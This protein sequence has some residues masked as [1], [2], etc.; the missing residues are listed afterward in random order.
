MQLFHYQAFIILSLN[1]ITSFSYSV[2]VTQQLLPYSSSLVMHFGLVE[3]R[4]ETGYY[5]GLLACS[6]MV[7]RTLLAPIWGHLADVHGRK[8]L[9]EFSVLSIFVIS[10]LFS[11]VPN[12]L[13]ALALRLMLG[14]LNSLS[15]VAKSAASECVPKEFVSYAMMMYTTG[16]FIGEVFGTGLGGILVGLVFED[17]PYA[18]PNL[19][20]AFLALSILLV[21]RFQFVETLPP[22]QRSSEPFSIRVL[23][24]IMSTKTVL[25]L[26]TIYGLSCFITLAMQEL[27]PLICW[28]EESVGG[29]NMSPQK[30][31]GVLTISCSIALIVQQF[32]YGRIVK[33][34]G[35]YTVTMKAQR[36]MLPII[37]LL[38]FTKHTGDYYWV[39]LVF[40]LVSVYMLNFQAITGVFI[41][42]N[43]SVP[44][45]KRGKLNGLGILWCAGFQ[46]IAPIFAGSSLAWSL[47]INTFP[48]DLHFTFILLS[49]I[50]G[51]QIFFYCK[52]KEEM[53]KDEMKFMELEAIP[54][55]DSGERSPVSFMIEK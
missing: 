40:G 35:H 51:F 43:E 7:G 8:P 19:I 9:I 34:Y 27:V 3:S 10:L 33:R 25:L 31:G 50:V 48:L 39:M 49:V 17:Y 16:S 55:D 24:D 52:V 42:L 44:D 41:Q 11:I 5:V 14:V 46:I 29:L 54:I 45:D 20:V 21:V 26:L 30:I 47:S 32:I 22:S 4:N 36:Y 53:A 23:L 38:P 37:F 6:T 13:A 12:Y 1:F 2:T 28:A 18:M 15:I